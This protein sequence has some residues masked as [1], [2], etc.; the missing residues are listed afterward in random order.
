MIAKSKSEESKKLFRVILRAQ[1]YMGT[2]EQWHVKV[3]APNFLSALQRALDELEIDATKLEGS[4]VTMA[5]E[6]TEL[7]EGKVFDVARRARA[8]G[9]RGAWTFRED[10]PDRRPG[11]PRETELL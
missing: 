4:A 3:V 11:G 2:A 1:E 6:S 5:A 7:P 9:E 10:L 8:F